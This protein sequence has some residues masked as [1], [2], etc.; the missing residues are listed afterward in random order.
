MSVPV[1][2]FCKGSMDPNDPGPRG[3]D[4]CALLLVTNWAKPPGQRKEQ[5]F[6]CHFECFRRVVMRNDFLPFP[7]EEAE[8]DESS[9]R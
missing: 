1:C 6:L 2:C 8:S 7:W 5:E 9:P 4:P 3:A